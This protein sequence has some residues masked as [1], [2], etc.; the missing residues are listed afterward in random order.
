TAEGAR[1]EYAVPEGPGRVPLGNFLREV[2]ADGSVG[3]WVKGGLSEEAREERRRE[4]RRSLQ[5]AR[6]RRR[7]GP[8]IFPMLRWMEVRQEEFLHASAFWMSNGM[9]EVESEEE[10]RVFS[11]AW[12]GHLPTCRFEGECSLVAGGNTGA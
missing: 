11:E 4:E 3:P 5:E 12:G 2:K 8:R 9:P 10:R 6:A 7:P 1:Y